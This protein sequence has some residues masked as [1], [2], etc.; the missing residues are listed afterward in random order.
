MSVVSVIQ[1]THTPTHTS[2]L[3]HTHSH[4]HAHTHTHIHEASALCHVSV[5]VS[6][7]CLAFFSSCLFFSLSTWKAERSCR[8][9]VSQLVT[10]VPRFFFILSFF[11][12]EHMQV[13][14]LMSCY[15]VTVSYVRARVVFALKTALFSR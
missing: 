14:A 9:I 7:S 2:T 4:T 13:S 10:F 3:A 11:F 15:C 6:R 5:I 8:V 1:D 12:P